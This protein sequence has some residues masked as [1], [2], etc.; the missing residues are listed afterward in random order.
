[1]NSYFYGKVIKSGTKLL[2]NV[3]RDERENF[4]HKTYVKVYALDVEEIVKEEVIRTID[5]IPKEMGL[6]DAKEIIESYDPHYEFEGKLGSEIMEH[7]KEL[8]KE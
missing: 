2:I 7:A 8:V 3:P 4:K 6:V 5:E 1:M